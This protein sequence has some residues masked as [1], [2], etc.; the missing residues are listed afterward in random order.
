MRTVL[1][2]AVLACVLVS[3]ST[4]VL[5]YHWP[6]DVIGGWLAVLLVLLPALRLLHATGTTPKAEPPAAV[7]L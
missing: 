6:T 2:G 4:L 5:G 7:S 1:L 3:L